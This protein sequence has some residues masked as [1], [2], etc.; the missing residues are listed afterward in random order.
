MYTGGTTFTSETLR[1]ITKSTPAARLSAVRREARSARAGSTPTTRHRFPHWNWPG[2]E[3]R[4][5]DV[6]VFSNCDEVELLLNDRSLG[7]QTMT[8]N[9]HL[10]WEVMYEPGALEA[11]GYRGGQCVATAKVETVGPA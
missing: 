5:I 6:R 8:I 4:A 1:N 11:F 7:R 3:G 2:R 10:A 9:S